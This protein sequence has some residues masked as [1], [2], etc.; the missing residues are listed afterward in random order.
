MDGGLVNPQP[1]VFQ[2]DEDEAQLNRTAEEKAAEL[3]ES[4]EDAIDSL[5]VFELIRHIRDPEHPLSLEELKVVEPSLITVDQAAKIVTI[6]FTPTVPHCS[7]TSLIGLCIHLALSRTLPAFFKID[8]SV[9]PGSHNQERQVNQQLG[10]KERVAA[11]LE[12]PNLLAAVENCI[13]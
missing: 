6:C 7:L 13:R 5:E 8:I 12:N 11:A 10:D 1:I 2:R 9:T 4:V 3:D